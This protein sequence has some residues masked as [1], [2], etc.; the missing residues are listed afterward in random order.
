M[1]RLIPCAKGNGATTPVAL[2]EGWTLTGN[3]GPSSGPAVVQQT[4]DLEDPGAAFSSRPTGEQL[5][6]LTSVPSGMMT[7]SSRVR[8]TRGG[9]GRKGRKNERNL[10]F[11]NDTRYPWRPHLADRSEIRITGESAGGLL[12]TNA[13]ADTFGSVQFT[14]AILDNFSA[15]ASVFDEYF[16]E[17]IEFVTLPQPTEIVTLGQTAGIYV[18][19]VDVDD[20][21]APTSFAQVASYGS[22]ITTSGTVCHYHEWEPNF[23][24][25]VYSGAFTSF[26]PGRGWIDCA[27]PNVVHYGIKA[28]STASTASFTISYIVKLWVRFRALH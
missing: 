16:I 15:L 3:P 11:G 23:E 21:V 4:A 20:A 26:A 8:P 17:K 9:R 14:A 25:A 19:A 27:S 7:A 1:S 24:V 18:T 5:S 2:K 12:V 10:S 6:R 22:S 28:A 13:V